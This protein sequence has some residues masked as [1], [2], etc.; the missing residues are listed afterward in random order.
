MEMSMASGGLRWESI[1]YR[2]DRRLLY[3]LSWQRTR[4]LL[5][6]TGELSLWLTAC[7]CTA[8]V[9]KLFTRARFL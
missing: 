9:V 3:L 8:R 1:R 5:V 2:V 4:L 7:I 6:D